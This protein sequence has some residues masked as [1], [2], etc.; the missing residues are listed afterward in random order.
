M[1]HGDSQSDENKTAPKPKQESMCIFDFFVA[2]SEN[3][4]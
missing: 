4:H 2:N 1:D 3:N